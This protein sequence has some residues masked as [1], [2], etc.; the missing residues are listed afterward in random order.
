MLM[1]PMNNLMI[2]HS[3]EKSDTIY[4]MTAVGAR[5]KQSTNW[6][7]KHNKKEIENKLWICKGCG[8]VFAIDEISRAAKY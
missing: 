5:Y 7:M 6:K 3:Y 1:G 2:T 4:E 8:G